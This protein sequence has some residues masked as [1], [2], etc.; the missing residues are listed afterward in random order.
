M[1]LQAVLSVTLLGG[2]ASAEQVVLNSALREDSPYTVFPPIKRVAVIGAGPSGLQVAAELK[3]HGFNITIFDRAP[4]PGGNWRFTDE[5]PVRESYPCVLLSL[6]PHSFYVM[7]TLLLLASR[8]VPRT[9]LL[10]LLFLFRDG[11]SV[12]PFS[13]FGNLIKISFMA[14]DS[15][16]G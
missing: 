12:S 6:F 3:D 7:I 16:V 5:I 2:L 4:G 1:R 8:H 14:V 13:C 15:F 11:G 10:L 9:K